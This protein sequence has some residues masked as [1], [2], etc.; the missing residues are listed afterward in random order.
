MVHGGACA[1][2]KARVARDWSTNCT[3]YLRAASCAIR[4]CN[5]EL[6]NI[7]RV[8]VFRNKMASGHHIYWNRSLVLVLHLIGWVG[9]ESFL[10]QSQSVVKQNQ[11]NINSGLLSTQIENRS[12]RCGILHSPDVNNNKKCSSHLKI[13]PPST[14]ASS[15]PWA[16]T[17]RTR[18][19]CLKFGAVGKIVI[20]Y[21]FR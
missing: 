9:G 8:Q 4:A 6:Y 10:N 15:S 21:N 16:L 19:F 12:K 5:Q 20:V 17:I 2:R 3:I 18:S 7:F 14:P 11:S 1:Q 13:P